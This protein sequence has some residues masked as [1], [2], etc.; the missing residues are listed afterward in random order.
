MHQTAFF[1]FWFCPYP[2]FFYI[3]LCIIFLVHF[4]STGC[5][6]HVSSLLVF[7]G[8]STLL[9][10][11]KKPNDFLFHY[12]PKS[13][14]RLKEDLLRWLQ[15]RQVSTGTVETADPPHYRRPLLLWACVESG[16]GLLE[17]CVRRSPQIPVPGQGALRTGVFFTNSWYFL[18]GVPQQ[19]FLRYQSHIISWDEFFWFLNTDYLHLDGNDRV[20]AAT[21]SRREERGETLPAFVCAT[22]ESVQQPQISPPPQTQVQTAV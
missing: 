18:D 19:L 4:K 15:Y 2:I 21:P 13:Q 16:T 20:L 8:S 3:H 17:N 5:L 6:E 1:L 9:A 10:V 11:H 14:L 22:A 12:R 7:R